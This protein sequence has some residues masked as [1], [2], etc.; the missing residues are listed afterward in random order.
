MF[1]HPCFTRRKGVDSPGRIGP[2]VKSLSS[3]CRD[4]TDS[5]NFP[6]AK[7]KIF[8]NTK[9]HPFGD[10]KTCYPLSTPL[11]IM[12][13]PFIFMRHVTRSSRINLDC[14]LEIEIAKIVCFEFLNF[15]LQ[16]TGKRISSPAS[17]CYYIVD[18]VCVP[19]VSTQS[20]DCSTF[21]AA[22]F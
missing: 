17:I 10:L 20:V 12:L 19:I 22:T 15:T 6:R 18:F 13:Y 11:P 14:E 4:S 3:I 21:C 8:G 2:N 5:T 1:Y 7:L 9:C 16:F